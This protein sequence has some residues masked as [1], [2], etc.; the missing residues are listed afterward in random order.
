[1]LRNA[2]VWE[3]PDLLRD[4]KPWCKCA[5]VKSR[6]IGDGHPTFNRNPYNYNGYI[7]P[8]Y[9]VD[10]HSL[11]YGNNGSLEPG[12]NGI[13][14]VSTGGAAYSTNLWRTE[15]L[16]APNWRWMC[17]ICRFLNPYNK[18]CKIPYPDN[19]YVY[20]ARFFRGN[21]GKYSRSHGVSVI[22]SGQFI[23]NP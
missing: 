9:W 23:I 21:L 5:M 20:M 19:P 12:T 16:K 14:S 1:M 17:R 10:D 8:Y 11:L 13:L 2:R 15:G 18:R 6:Y 3:G 22:Q 4:R 7:N